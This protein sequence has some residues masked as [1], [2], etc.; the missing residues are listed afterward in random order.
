MCASRR[1]NL[2]NRAT[3]GYAKQEL[4]VGSIKGAKVG[5]N[6]KLNVR[7]DDITMRN[8]ATLGYAEQEVN[9]GTIK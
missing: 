5:G 1:S 8:R 7:A 2:D 4:N 6:V 3:L 9:L